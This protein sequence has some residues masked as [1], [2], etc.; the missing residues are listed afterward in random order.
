VRA[1]VEEAL[2]L[3]PEARA[4]FLDRACGG[5]TELRAEVEA[6]LRACEQAEQSPEFLAGSAVAFATPLL[7]GEVDGGTGAMDSGDVTRSGPQAGAEGGPATDVP[8]ALRTA[9]AGHYDV[10][11]EVG[12]GGTATV[13]LAHDRR[14]GR[15][16][17]LKLFDPVLGAAMSTERFL[18]EIRVT[19]GLTHPHILPL[20]E[21][22]EAGGLLFAV[23]PDVVG[24]T[25]RERLARE[26]ALAPAAALR[27]VREVASALAYAHRR[28]IVHR[29]IKPANILIEDGHAVV[30]DFGIARAVS[31]AREPREAGAPRHA[32]ADAPGDE[33]GTLTGAGT[34]LGTPAYMAPEQARGD[35]VVDHRA[36]LYALG[37]VAYEALAGTHPFGRRTPA[38]LVAA[39]RDESPPSLDARRPDVPPAFAALVMRCLEKDPAARPQSAAEVVAA[40]DAVRSGVDAAGTAPPRMATWKVVSLA[41]AVVALVAAGGVLATRGWTAGRQAVATPDAASDT[42]EPSAIRTVAVLPFVNTSGVA[43]DNYFS[44]GL[45]DELAHALAQ[46]PGVRVAGRTSSYSFQGKA[47]GAREIGR[48]LDVGALVAGAVRRAGDRMRV[49]TQL[50]STADGKVLWDS[51]YESRASDVFAVQDEFTRAIVAALAPSLG[52]HGADTVAPNAQRGTTDQEAY[53][54]YLKG[55]YFW[56]Q[57]GAANVTHAIS[58][59]QQAIRRDATFARAHAGLAM[60]YAVLPDYIPDPADTLSTLAMASARRAVALDST[61]ADAQLALG[62]AL[63]L[64]L[65]FRDAL[66]RYRAGL[67]LEPSSE[68]VHHWLGFSLLN[69]GHT[70]EALVELRRATQLDPLA[71]APA[72]ALAT[73]LLF[74]RRFP[75][76]EDASRRALTLDS[77]YAFAIWT[78][79]LAQAFGGE[80][81]SAVRTLERGTRLHPDDSRLYSALLFAYAAAGRW[82]DAERIRARLQRPGGDPYGGGEAAFAEL[83]FGNREPLVRLLTTEAG[84]RSREEHGGTFGCDP[85]LDPLWRDARF[86]A[87]MRSLMVEACPLARA[88]PVPQRAGAPVVRR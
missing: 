56:L 70:D 24:D 86:R 3:A 32:S 4:A 38:E 12:H 69:L 82:S 61:L 36:D 42:R 80:P 25:L 5:D 34:A 45:T 53:D 13:Y 46:L 39:H 79:G 74:A 64:R 60:A 52:D 84:Q 17:A 47:V 44:D 10:E 83:V 76:A 6:Q 40:L 15:P 67:A 57:R 73:A 23:M 31:R 21:S 85:L 51:V 66:A 63:D 1:T 8:A 55:R 78:L 77:T 30:A 27:L 65:R 71:T 49:T 26:G 75:E 18:H 9:L 48:A 16:V 58:Y 35:A 20:D 62:I 88:W 29:D 87:A 22:C 50:V 68:T 43:T 54:L 14:H 72:S 33:T 81:D 2:A 37:V 41:A 19:A 11:R 7:T 28:G 59:F